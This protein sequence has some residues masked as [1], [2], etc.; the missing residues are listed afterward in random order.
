[1][2]QKMEDF[3]VLIIGGGPAGLSAGLWCAD[4]GLK[5]IIFEKEAECGGQLLRIYNEITNY[6]GIETANGREMRDLFLRQVEKTNV[7]QLCNTA[8]AAVDLAQRKI[9]LADGKGYSARTI[10]IATGVSRRKLGVP[11]EMEF[12][13]RGILKSGEKAKNEV[14]G[15]R[16]LIVGG[17]DAALENSLIL[18][19]TAEKVFVVHRG[20]KFSAR[21]EFVEK[22]AGTQ[23]IEFIF[24]SQLTGIIGGVSVEAVDVKDISSGTLSSISV[25][26]VLIRVGVEPNTS[27]FRGQIAL[28]AA[29]FISI[30]NNFSTDLPDVFAIGDVAN[31]LYPTISGAVGMGASVAKA[32]RANLSSLAD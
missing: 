19:R 12:E 13:G 6:L 5:T 24:R 23:N 4:L 18:S 3:D 10:V 17:G 32:L 27:L 16:V 26:A 15:K 11:G 14:A 8:I 20:S 31:G 21:E 2:A 30:D 25:D 22:A 28:S 9:I 1:M 7:T 29:D